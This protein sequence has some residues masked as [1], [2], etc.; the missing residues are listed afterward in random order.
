MDGSAVRFWLVA[1]VAGAPPAGGPAERRRLPGPNIPVLRLLE[2]PA[3]RAQLGLTLE[4]ETKIFTLMEKAKHLRERIREDAVAK[5]V[6]ER[7]RAAGL[8]RLALK[9]ERDRALEEA[10]QAA[11]PDFEAIANEAEAVLTADQAA[12]LRTIGRE[13]VRR[14]M[15]TGGLSALLSSPARER[16]GLSDEQVEKIRSILKDLEPPPLKRRKEAAGEAAAG[17]SEETLKRHA[18][19]VKSARAR[20]MEVLTPEQ[21]DKAEQVLSGVKPSREG[22]PGKRRP[23]GAPAPTKGYQEAV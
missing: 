18:E 8:D 4:Q 5:S 12:K 20:I 11:R 19:L 13:N 3:A 9:Q 14:Q 15:A 16:L 1:D 23:P 22:L 21:R 6:G 2:D 17:P 10:M 7:R